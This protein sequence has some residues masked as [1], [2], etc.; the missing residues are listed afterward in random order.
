MAL[1]VLGATVAVILPL[2]V[3]VRA[4][5]SDATTLLERLREGELTL[6][7]FEALLAR[8]T[9]VEVDLTAALRAVLGEVG[10]DGVAAWSASSASSRTRSSGSG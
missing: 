8:L 5:V 9:G 2:V 1:L 3:V 6:G 4:T 7:G 10:T